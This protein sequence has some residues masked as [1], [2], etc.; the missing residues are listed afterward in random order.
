MNLV[1]AAD[2]DETNKNSTVKTYKKFNTLILDQTNTCPS[3]LNNRDE[4]KGV[5]FVKTII[6]ERVKNINRVNHK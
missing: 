1:I 5:L 4:N 2:I 6:N 3:L